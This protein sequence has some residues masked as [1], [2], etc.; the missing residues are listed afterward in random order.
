VEN[1]RLSMK[2]P[3]FHSL[4]DKKFLRHYVL[5][6]SPILLCLNMPDILPTPSKKQP[7]R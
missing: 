2:T 4:N 6:A 1:N 7:L 5:P 3:K